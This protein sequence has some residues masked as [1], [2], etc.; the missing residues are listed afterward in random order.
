MNIVELR[1]TPKQRRILKEMLLLSS[2]VYNMANYEARQ[3]F[4]RGEKSPSA[5][6]LQRTL[7]AKDD[8][9]MLG[10]SYALPR[11]QIYGETQSARFKLIKSKTQA[12]VGLPKY[13]KNRRTNTTLPSYLV[14][15]GRQYALGSRDVRIPL[16]RKLREKHGLKAFRLKY[17][18]VLRWR[19]EQARG[20]IHLKGKK[21]YLYQSVEMPDPKP[22][23]SG[24][25]AGID[26]GI[27]N[28]MAIVTSEGDELVI[29]SK[30]FR[31]QWEHYGLLIAAEQQKLAAINRRSS[32]KL[33]RLFAKR[34]SYQNHLFNNVNAKAFR[35]L[36]R[37]NV[38]IVCLGDVTGIREGKD[39]G[40]AWNRG[41]HNYWSYDKESAKIA[42]KTEEY[43]MRLVQPMEEYTTQEC[44]ICTERNK[45][46]D[47]IYICSFC[48]YIDHRDIVGA[49][50]IRVK[51]MRDL[52]GSER[53]AHQAEIRLS[54]EVLA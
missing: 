10:R 36:K 15:D 38:G 41:L 5:I 51:G 19:G 25:N 23:E 35:F 53:S 21:F 24:V 26:L 11:L 4:F 6:D 33:Q 8:Y 52:L 12:H 3:A 48:G 45:P 17:N 44:P 43:G 31:R 29:G 28:L 42:N 37:H 14:M 40:A 16:S 50:N 18:G 7:Q 2:C 54:P 47:R 27:K 30:R 9:Q 46:K 13:L 32:R 22:V 20:Q 1:P 34:N 49:T 39:W